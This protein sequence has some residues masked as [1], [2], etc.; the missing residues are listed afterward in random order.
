MF[1]SYRFLTLA[2]LVIAAAHLVFS[3]F[4]L[5]WTMRWI[6][7]PMHFLAGV[8]VGAAAGSFLLHGAPDF[9]KEK[10]H[11]LF[12]I[13]FITGAAFFVGVFW[14]FF[15]FF[16][17]TYIAKDPRVVSM[18]NLYT[19]TLFDLTMDFLGSAVAVFLFALKVRKE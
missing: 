7:I 15:E 14:E 17:S 4:Y 19:D 8:W 18:G 12:H 16:L 11:V 1:F 9:A 5:Y 3:I 2:L 10:R 13:L 6:D